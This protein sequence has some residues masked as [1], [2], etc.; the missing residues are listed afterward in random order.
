M[1]GF[2]TESSVMNVAQPDVENGNP[3]GEPIDRQDLYDIEH[4]TNFWN[5]KPQ[6][7]IIY[8]TAMDENISPWGLLAAVMA[9]RMSHVPP[10]VVLV[11]NN[12]NEGKTLEEGTSLNLFVGLVGR[13]SAGKSVTFRTATA[14]IAP[15]DRPLADGTGQGIVKAFAERKKITKDDEG[16]PLDTPYT[17]T[18]FHRHSLTLHAPEI[19]TLNAEFIREG[20]KTGG[21]MRSMWVG[22]TVG[23]TNAD[24]ERNAVLPQNMSRLCGIWG[25]QPHN[26]YAIMGQAKSG[27]PQRFLWVPVRDRRAARAPHLLTNVAAAPVNTTFPF[28]VFG[29]T[30]AAQAMGTT[31]PME[32]RDDD[33]L[34]APVW[35]HHSAQAAIEVKAAQS[36]FDAA[37]GDYEDYDD[38]PPEVEAAV[39]AAEMAGH[40]VLQKLKVAAGLG[41]LWGHTE[42]DDED[43][44]LACAMLEISQGEAAGVW[45]TCEKDEL[46]SA[47][48][49]GKTRGVEMDAATT[50][51]EYLR[52]ARIE[53]VAGTV[54]TILTTARG[55]TENGVKKKIAKTKRDHV[56]DALRHLEDQGKAS[57]DGAT[58]H[59]L[60]NG[61]ALR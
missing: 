51:R 12:G 28:P 42:P 27:T 18:R 61:N 54:Y 37:M 19:E 25:V 29:S 3:F 47:E 58:W 53:D 21:M 5:R 33:P 16:K 45:K 44:E 38:L 24:S 55:C 15:K 52:T 23:M 30:P 43:V 17:V 14:L 31:L 7:Q 2:H 50:A 32:L 10:N 41:F 6:L 9:H 57:Y 39:A 48:L 22:E 49:R 35:V 40:G 56:R 36:L 8:H 34:P 1:R 4:A 13:A 26:A 20:S 60:Y 11:K 59:A 46:K